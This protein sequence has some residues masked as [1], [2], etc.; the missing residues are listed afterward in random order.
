MSYAEQNYTID[1]LT[2]VINGA[3][4]G[5][6]PA[7]MQQF[8][9]TVGDTKVG[10]TALEPAD[11]E[12]DGQLIASCKGFKIVMNDDHYPVDETDGTVVVDHV[13]T[14]DVYTTEVTGLTN[15]QQ[16][17]FA[18]FPYT[19]HGVVNRAAGLRVLAGSHP[20]RQTATPQ[21]YVLYGFRRTK[22]DSNPAT[23][24][25]ATDM[26]V[27]LTPASMNASTGE[28][29]LGGWAN[30]WFVTGNKP[31][32][33]KSDGTIDYELNPNDYT[34][35]EDGTA[36]DVANS[37][38]GGNAM[39]LFPTVW[40]YRYEDATYEYVKVCNVKLNDNY[41]AYAHQRS[42]GTIMEWFARSIYDAGVVSNKARSISGLTPN[43]TVAGGTQLSYAQANGSL[44]DSDT[45]S[46][47]SLIW[48]L[49]TLMSLNDDVQTA[50]GY[51]WYTGMSKAGDL[52]A[53]GLGNTK[54]QFWGKRENN[55]VKV[56]HLENFWGNI[57]KIMQGLVYNT[58]GKYGVK[59]T[60][61]YNNSGSGYA[62]TAYGIG[63]TSGGY[64]SQHHT[65]E[66]GTLPYTVSGS[67]STYIPDGAWW[68]TTQ[69]NFARFGCS[70][71]GGLLVGRA[72][73]V[74]AALS[75]SSWAFGLALTCEQPLAA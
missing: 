15:D 53:A 44:W 69:Q 20:N 74:G 38:Y 3:A 16:Y 39:A 28:I 23:R 35:K 43:N 63:G 56:F 22:G 27:G 72:L 47:V 60:A 14:G 17:Y 54:G 70:G 26:A 66:Y 75:I 34:K 29:D 52:K 18:A 37:N 1:E 10:I 12:V 41:K 5:I 13:A 68:N 49:L 62:A 58:T 59:M 24:L 6:P 71:G 4:V 2:E 51:G 8:V 25:V 57:W 50:W 7:N 9:V 19:D 45:W 33:L 32:M 40:V 64:Q 42:D 55:T 31:V 73:D 65:S 11:T 61:P 67:D 21:V 48:D 46:R 30:A 36:S